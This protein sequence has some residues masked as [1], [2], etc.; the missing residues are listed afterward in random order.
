MPNPPIPL[1][2]DVDTGVDDAF[3]LM[4]A[5]RHPDLEL[6]AVTCVA[7]NAAVDQVVANTLYVLDTLDTAGA[8]EVPVAR[9][10][11]RP[12]LAP[13]HDAGHV[14]GPDGLGGFARPSD[15][16]ASSLSAVALLRQ[17]LLRAIGAGE[18]V[19]LVPL[20]PQTNIALLL[21]T[22]PEVAGGIERIVFMGGS[23]S[24][25]NATAAAEFNVWHDPEAA[26]IVLAACAELSIPVTMYG[27]DVFQRVTV[28]GSDAAR[29]RGLPDP[30]AQLA[31]ALI[32][33]QRALFGLE[34]CRIGDAGAVCAVL[35]PEGLGVETFPVRVEVA[36]GLARGQTIVDRR[37]WTGD[38]RAQAK[39]VQGQGMSSY[40]AAPAVPA[41]T[42]DV[43]L[44]VDAARYAALWLSAFGA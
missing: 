23:A 20:A 44:E 35:D 15:R 1:I 11:A 14:H 26:A 43:A 29:L 36:P 28:D 42:V 31:A 8:R 5:A 9:G 18:K 10:A 37:T 6:R 4:L 16:R 41:A 24:G 34:T 2:L 30:A 27:L 17:E 39:H 12:L 22:Y 25:G 3:A 33:Q 19:T 13:P 7:G 21:R 38:H 32:D 40:S